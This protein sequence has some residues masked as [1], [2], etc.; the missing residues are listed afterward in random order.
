MTI[1]TG[2]NFSSPLLEEVPFYWEQ[3]GGEVHFAA[4]S[5]TRIGEETQKAIRMSTNCF[6]MHVLSFS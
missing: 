2:L 3:V 1:R 5:R 4:G 6:P